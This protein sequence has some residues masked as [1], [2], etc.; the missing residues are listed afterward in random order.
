MSLDVRGVLFMYA[1]M[2]WVKEDAW[3]YAYVLGRVSLIAGVW[4]F[5]FFS[6]AGA[7]FVVNLEAIKS[8]ESGGNPTVV[9]KDTKCYGIYQIS[10]IC[11]NDF[12]EAHQKRYTK[13][14][15]FKPY[16]NQLIASWYF[17]RIGEQLCYYN[18]TLNLITV[19]ASYNWGIRHVRQWVKRG[20]KFEQLPIE[21]RCYIK[22][23][24]ALTQDQSLSSSTLPHHKGR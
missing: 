21:T 7:E 19:I 3:S 23:Y 1:V 4:I 6:L 12:N 22:K 14:D 13:E 18:I 11:L 16:V 2:A 17:K 10:E 24:V 15:L 5:F 20:M 8:I 9:S